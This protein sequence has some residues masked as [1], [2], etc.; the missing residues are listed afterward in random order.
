[1]AVKAARDGAAVVVRPIEPGDKDALLAGFERLSDESRYRRFLTPTPHLTDAQLR[2][3]TEVDHD[4]HEALIA[5]AEETGEPVGVARYV[6]FPDD[7]LTAEPAVTVVDHWQGRGVGTLLLDELSARARAAGVER[8]SATVLA[9]NEPII[10]LL[11]HLGSAERHREG[12]VVQVEAD[13]PA[14]G[15]PPPLRTA[16]REAARN[17]L[18]LLKGVGDL[19]RRD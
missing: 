7:P 6:R 2:Y 13:L 1:V 11:D 19:G 18:R 5:F 14:A 9:T 3:L 8:F 15:S 17:G 12:S 16:L 4:R 10:A